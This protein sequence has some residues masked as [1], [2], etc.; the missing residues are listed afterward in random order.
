MIIT[1]SKYKQTHNL[2][3]VY[4]PVPSRRLG[5]SLGIDLLPFKTCSLNC[6]YCQLGKTT[7]HTMERRPYVPAD[8]VLEEIKAGLASGQRVDY[9]T[10]SGSG[11]PTLHSELGEIIRKI[12]ELTTVPV[13]VITNSTS[14]PDQG[15]QAELMEADL[16]VPS[17]DA[18]SQKVFEKL[19]RPCYGLKV[20]P[21]I[22]VLR[23]F[24]Q[25][26][27]GLMWLEIMFVKGINNTDENIFKLKEVVEMI[28]PHKIH[29]NTVVHPP[30][31]ANVR[32]L[33]SQELQKISQQFGSTQVLL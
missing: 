3:Y 10:F 14:L 23:I 30:A 22:E 25:I 21:I 4:G 24:R 13:A 16:L 1:E 27:S 15:V 6:I 31:E 26:F 5:F 12:K 29:L 20:E 17:L 8:S 7:Q 11:E 9:I 18:A 28:E 19:N 2:S 32:A 33:S